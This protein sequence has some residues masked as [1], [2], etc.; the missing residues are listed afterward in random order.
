MMWLQAVATASFGGT[1]VTSLVGASLVGAEY[2]VAEKIGSKAVQQVAGRFVAARVGG[3]A[4]GAMVPVAGWVLLGVG[5]VGTV[6]AAV[7]EPTKLEAWARK[8]PFGSGPGGQK[9]KTLEEQ[10]KALNEA[11]EIASQS[12]P[13]QAKAA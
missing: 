4:V 1:G 2:L 8:T 5:I 10:N 12:E 3:M 7:L 13:T 9:F 11:L 6:G